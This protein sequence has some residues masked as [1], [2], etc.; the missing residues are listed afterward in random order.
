MAYLK[1][2][3]HPFNTGWLPLDSSG[4]PGVTGK[5]YFA[6]VWTSQG[7]GPGGKRHR[8]CLCALRP[9]RWVGG[10]VVR[11]L[12]WVDQLYRCI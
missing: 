4:N 12:W 8:H 2:A 3:A 6:G 10:W 9:Y 7:G 11:T 1:G 5:A